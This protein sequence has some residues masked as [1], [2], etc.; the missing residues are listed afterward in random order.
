MSD[1]P[2]ALRLS[3]RV[4]SPCVRYLARPGWIPVGVR[5]SAINCISWLYSVAAR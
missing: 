4:F 5:K 1:A 3:V 2:F